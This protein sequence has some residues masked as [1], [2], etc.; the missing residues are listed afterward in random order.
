[1]TTMQPTP[2]LAALADKVDLV[3]EQHAHRK[4]RLP[5]ENIHRA[6]AS[7]NRRNLIAIFS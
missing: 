2:F 6:S 3:P 5:I 1:M 4:P 7:L